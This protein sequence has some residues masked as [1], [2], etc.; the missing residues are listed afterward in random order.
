MTTAAPVVE[1]P[2]DARCPNCGCIALA[3]FHAAIDLD[4]CPHWVPG[5]G[6]VATADLTEADLAGIQAWQP[7]PLRYDPE[8][9]QC[10]G[11]CAPGPRARLIYYG[12]PMF[13]CARCFE[14]ILGAPPEA[15]RMVDTVRMSA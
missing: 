13:M 2:Q 15:D 11:S 7:P 9:D 14:N 12:E 6:W 10:H 8:Y 5:K 1:D 3:R 4:L